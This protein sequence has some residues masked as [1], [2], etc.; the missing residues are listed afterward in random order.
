MISK[1]TETKEL[2]KQLKKVN[3]Y[4][5]SN[6]FRI[7]EN[8]N[9]KTIIADQENGVTHHFLDTYNEEGGTSHGNE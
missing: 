9:L 6:I 2:I 5:E 3:P 4:V 8:V 7:V 1:R